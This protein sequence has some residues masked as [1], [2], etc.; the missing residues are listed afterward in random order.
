[1]IRKSVYKCEKLFTSV[2]FNLSLYKNRTF[3]SSLKPTNG[4]ITDSD[5]KK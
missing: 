4:Q 2:I 1:M 5:L 3:F